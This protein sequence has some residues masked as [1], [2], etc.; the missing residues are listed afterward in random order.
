VFSPDRSLS[1]EI[2]FLSNVFLCTRHPVLKRLARGKRHGVTFVT[3]VKPLLD[4]RS[5]CHACACT[6]AE[7]SPIGGIGLF[8]LY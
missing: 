6:G 1:R 7:G 4:G 3:R 2:L 8:V 5:V